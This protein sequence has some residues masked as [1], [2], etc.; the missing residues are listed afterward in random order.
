MIFDPDELTFSIDGDTIGEVWEESVRNLVERKDLEMV[1]SDTGGPS[2]EAPLVSLRVR[3]PDVQPQSSSAFVEPELIDSYEGLLRE[4]SGQVADETK[5]LAN[6]IYAY[7]GPRG[8]KINQLQLCWRE[9]EESSSSRRAII[10][11]WE[12]AADLAERGTGS[13]ASHVFLQLTVRS[14]A[15]NIVVFSRSVDAWLGALP[16]MLG[17]FSL[18]KKTA[19]KL[20]LGIGSYSHV[21]VSYHIYMRDIPAA[22]SA[23]VQ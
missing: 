12:P 22:R 3:H 23:L 8:E 20:G 10:Q 5:T 18:Q 7:P 13:P 17:F 21:I 19:D 1:D 16:N 4:R 6:R 15:V 11:L 2:L 9:L 14:G